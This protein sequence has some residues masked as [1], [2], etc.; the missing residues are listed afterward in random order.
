[1]SDMAMA[2]TDTNG[3]WINVNKYFLNELGYSEQEFLNLTHRD[4]THPD[5]VE[6]TSQLFSKLLSGEMDSYQLEKRYKTKEGDFK[7]FYLSVKT[8]NDEN[9]QIT[10]VMGAGHPINDK[11]NSEK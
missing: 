2:A 8:I 11:I 3:Q 5:D 10:S 1:M 9:N 4:I 7:W 6:K